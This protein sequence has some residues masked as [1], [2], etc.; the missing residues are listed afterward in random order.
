MINDPTQIVTLIGD[1]HLA[2]PFGAELVRLLLEQD[3]ALQIRKLAQVGAG[4][5]TFPATQLGQPG[6]GRSILAV[7]ALGTNDYKTDPATWAAQ[8]DRVARTLESWPDEPALIWIG[9]PTISDGGT[10]WMHYVLD[11][12]LSGRWIIVDSVPLTADLLRGSDGIH[13][14]AAA[15]AA[16]AQRVI[17]QLEQAPADQRGGGGIASGASKGSG[18]ILAGLALAGVAVAGV[19]LAR[20]GR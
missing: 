10:D 8:V 12:A 1:S 18:W 13:Y 14:G 16:W 3:P 20:R 19:A 11:Q 6:P 15:G 5:R 9:P 2:G 17:A 4:V 7:V